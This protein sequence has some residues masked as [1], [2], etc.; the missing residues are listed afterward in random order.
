VGTDTFSGETGPALVD[1]DNNIKTVVRSWNTGNFVVGAR[2][3]NPVNVTCTVP[4][5]VATGTYRLRMVV[6]PSGGE[7]RIATISVENSPTSIDFEVR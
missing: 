3:S 7:W 4:N 1:N 5:T 2:N 6:R